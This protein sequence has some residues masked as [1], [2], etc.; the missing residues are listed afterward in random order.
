MDNTRPR[1][2]VIGLDGATFDVIDPLIR[3]GRLPHLAGLMERGV[4]G[5]LNSTVTPNSFPA[6]VTC[7]T[8]V[9]PGKHGI[10]WSLIRTGSGSC[11]FK[12]MSSR[13]IRA[14]RLWHLLGDQG[15]RVGV[16]NLPTEYPPEAVNG[17][18][19]CGALSPGVES[20][21]TYP[22]G[23]REEILAAVPG[24]RCEVDFARSNSKVLAGQLLRSIEN[25]ERLLLHLLRNHP[26]DLFF[27]VFTETDIAQHKFWA[28][29]D[30]RHP[31]HPRLKGELKTFVHRVYERLDRAVG[32]II[33]T[34][35]RNT[36]VMII[37]D[38]GF[39][40][41]YQSFSLPR[42]LTEKKYLV[43]KESPVRAGLKKVLQGA[44][45]LEKTKSAGRS[46][47]G[48]FQGS[49]RRLDSRYLRER[50]ASASGNLEGTVD[51]ERSR[52]YFGGD[53]GIRLN[54][55]GREP[56]GIVSPGREENAL[57][58]KIRN[59]LENL[60]YSNGRPVFKKVLT[61]EEAFRGSSLDRAPDLI[62][63]IDHS[64]APPAP[65]RWKFRAV[66]PGISGAHS[67]RGI[68]I[69]A[70]PGV[71]R[72]RSLAGLDI[73]DITPT[74]LYMLDH[75]LTR[76][77]DGRVMKEI[78]R[79]ELVRRRSTRREGFSLREPAK[80]KTYTREN[81]DEIIGRLRALGYI[82]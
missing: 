17:F 82:D 14:R 77:M 42:W 56:R 35:P 32:E 69:A 75:P 74:I 54:L 22:P 21:F 81:E 12:L 71:G 28:G 63:V 10:F 45:L 43:L 5:P 40:P 67:S 80:E 2:V 15:I 61:K 19:V 8:G 37:S 41:Y 76:D 44:G 38:H 18:M 20:E 55:R 24:Y 27:A 53:Q 46:L 49:R 78:F 65:E 25:R 70:G 33:R 68:F 7:T 52:A 62:P 64:Q 51:W 30:P 9:N 60:T 47:A 48:R 6:W 31:D 73:I 58:E 13:D 23:L 1:V 66:L 79:P 50:E 39:G 11:R 29:I 16:V 3:E 4:S 34:V 57:K 59:E 36:V 26:W 72:G